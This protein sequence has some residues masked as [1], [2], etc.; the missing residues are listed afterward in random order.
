MCP[1]RKEQK[2]SLIL[3]EHGL[4]G[5]TDKKVAF[6]DVVVVAVDDVY[7]LSHFWSCIILFETPSRYMPL[8]CLSFKSDRL[9]YLSVYV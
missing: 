4:A 1:E 9:I 8:Y 3:G 7:L 6:V 5:A 2:N